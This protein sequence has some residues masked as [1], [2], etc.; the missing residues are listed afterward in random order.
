MNQPIVYTLSTCPTCEKLRRA[1]KQQGIA[2]E[3]RPV[4]QRQAWLDEALRHADTVPIVV[5]PD[6]RVEVG[7]QGET[8]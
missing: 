7:F 2:F 1:W 6:G 3:E 8:G 5:H 4:N